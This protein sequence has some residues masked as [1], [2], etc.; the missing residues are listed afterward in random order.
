[1]WISV[2][3]FVA[4]LVIVQQ[5]NLPYAPKRCSQC[6]D[7]VGPNNS[8]VGKQFF[9]EC[10]DGCLPHQPICI[11]YYGYCTKVFEKIIQLCFFLKKNPL[12]SLQNCKEFTTGFCN[13]GFSTTLM[14]TT[15]AYTD[16]DGG[17]TQNRLINGKTCRLV[18]YKICTLVFLIDLR[19]H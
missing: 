7:P 13:N 10:C 19:T 15:R 18:F 11:K 16:L 2:F 14:P 3:A 4:S 6:A 5:P 8:T 17:F 9:C 12:L 1:M